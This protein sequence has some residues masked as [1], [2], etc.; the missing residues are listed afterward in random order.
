M[1]CEMSR[2]PDRLV[3]CFLGVS[4]EWKGK[5]IVTCPEQ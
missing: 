2:V 4:V 1:C 3:A 5:W